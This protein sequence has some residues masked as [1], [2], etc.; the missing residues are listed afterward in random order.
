MQW[1]RLVQRESVMPLRA[2]KGTP[3]ARSAEGSCD[4]PIAAACACAGYG[5]PA[6]LQRHRRAAFPS[7]MPTLR[8]DRSV[9]ATKLTRMRRWRDPRRWR[10]SKQLQAA[11]NPK[12]RRTDY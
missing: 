4:L 3:I 11:L 7:A 1:E 5:N 12:T 8:Y 6:S 2:A 10:D 9:C